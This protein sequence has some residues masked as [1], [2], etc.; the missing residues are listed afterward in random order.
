MSGRAILVAGLSALAA[1]CSP[2][3]QTAPVVSRGVSDTPPAVVAEALEAQAVND[4]PATVDGMYIDK[5]ACPGEGCYFGRAQALKAVDLYETPGASPVVVGQIQEGEWVDSIATEDR[6][7]PV[8]GIM[9]AD[10]EPFKEGDIVYRLGNMGEGCFDVWSKGQTGMWCD[11]GSDDPIE[12]GGVAW[13]TERPVTDGSEGWW[14]QVK[15]ANGSGGWLR[16][17]HDFRCTGL[18]DRE[19]DCPP[20][21]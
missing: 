11:I 16:G 10:V 15:R 13:R 18:Q 12:N 2:N 17:P 20:L 1:A 5:G 8:P 6:F 9:R 4:A 14:V 7:A 3:Q 19:A 21:P